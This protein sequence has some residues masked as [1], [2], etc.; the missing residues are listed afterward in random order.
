VMRQIRMLESSGHSVNAIGFGRDACG[1]VLNAYQPPKSGWRRRLGTGLRLACARLA[2]PA[3]VY[4]AN[5]L[6]RQ[7]L[8]NVLRNRPNIIHANDW[9]TLPIAAEAARQLRSL[10]VY[11]THEYAVGER[12]DDFLWRELFRPYID[13]L[14]S[15]HIGCADAVVTV[16]E[17]IAA[18]LQK[19]RRLAEK[20]VVVRN[21]PH[22]SEQP[23]RPT[24]DPIRVLYQGAFLPDRGLEALILSVRQWRDGRR[25]LLRGIGSPRYLERLRQ[26]AIDTAGPERIEFL[27]PV[28]PSQLVFSANAADIGIHP[29]P[30]LTIQTDCCLPNKFFEYVM[31]GLCLV[32]SPA[33]EMVRLVTEHDLG[34]VLPDTRPES[35]AA[36]INRLTPPAVDAYKRRALAAARLLNWEME[37]QILMAVYDRLREKQ[38]G[39]PVLGVSRKLLTEGAGS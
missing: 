1:G 7:M 30:P 37:E 38:A 15:R 19:L 28:S 31:A 10:V 18:H 36:I 2:P 39:E 20:P 13:D 25:L 35:I 9:L 3:K 24:G 6:N 32:V 29:I 33:R 4:W 34:M 27:A 16:S 5:R 23:Y 17:G 12:E 8:T 14:E 22:Y 21:V 26:L 11:D